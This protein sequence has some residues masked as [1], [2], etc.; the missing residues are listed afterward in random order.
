M[1]FGTTI[2]QGSFTKTDDNSHVL[3]LRSGFDWIKIVNHTQAAD[4][5]NGYGFEYFW[6]YGMGTT[7]IMKY[8]PAADHTVAVDE[9]ASAFTSIDSSANPLTALVAVTAGT[10]ATRP[11]YSTGSTAGLSDGDIV[12]ITGTAH[13]NINGLDFMVDDVTLNTSFRL[14]NTLSRAPGVIAGADGY[15]RKVKYDPIFSPRGRTIANIT[16]AN[17]GVV[18]TLVDHG[19][20]TGDKVRLTIPAGTAGGGMIELNNQTV[21]VTVIDSATFSIGIDTSGYTAFTYPLAAVYYTPSMVTPVGITG[22]STYVEGFDDAT[23]NNSIIGV[24]LS[25]GTTG[26]GGNNGDTIYWMA[27]KSFNI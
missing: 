11:V 5:N 17:P 15:W 12:R 2:Q 8:H 25:G 21:T 20:T 24:E 14:A 16:Q 4:T 1:S 9:V 23:K 13:T 19:Y 22:T 6:Q 10:N 26:P 7:G 18:T 27:G 3:T